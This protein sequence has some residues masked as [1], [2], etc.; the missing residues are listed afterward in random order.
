MAMKLPLIKAVKNLN[1]KPE[2]CE[3]KL[4]ST[5]GRRH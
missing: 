1:M 2:F 3:L 5:G 4:G